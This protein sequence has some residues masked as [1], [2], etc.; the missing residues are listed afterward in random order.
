MGGR[1]RRLDAVWFDVLGKFF[2]AKPK[3]MDG[4]LGEFHTR[5]RQLVDELHASAAGWTFDPA[6][7]MPPPAVFPLPRPRL[8]GRGYP[9]ARP[10]TGLALPDG[11]RTGDYDVVLSEIHI[12]FAT[13]IGPVFEWSLGRTDYPLSHYLRSRTGPCACCVSPTPGHETPG[14]RC[15]H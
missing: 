13:T 7:S 10:A 11:V 5:W 15:R 3:P 4:V 12:S 2:G 1:A 6:S 8:A 9:L 14:G